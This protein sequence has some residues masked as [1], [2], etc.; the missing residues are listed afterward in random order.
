MEAQPQR[1][2]QTPF[3]PPT[4]APPPT[5]R[6]QRKRNQTLDHLAATAFDLFEA[7]GYDAVTMEQIAAQA[8]VAKGTLYNHFPVKEALLAH[9]F[10]GELAAGL[11]QL[12]GA[13]DGL[14]S[15][16]ARLCYLLSASAD[17]CEA[18]RGYLPH[19]LRF[20]FLDLGPSRFG[21]GAGTNSGTNSDA[22]SRARSDPSSGTTSDASAE[23]SADVS[24][25]ANVG[26]SA[27]ANAGANDIGEAAPTRSGMDLAFDALMAAAQQ[28]GELRR[29]LPSG[30]LATLFHHL[31][32]GALM[33]WLAAP[34]G[35][36]RAEFAAIVDLFFHGAARAAEP[37]RAP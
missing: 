24:A 11:Q 17:W 8:D 9:Q 29:D 37:E 10:H 22:K 35:D 18:R 6:R 30:Q 19:Y 23:S 5:G 27:S 36:L 32:L 20:R 14:G 34:A 33:R 7:H 3:D 4:A 12:R 26:A 15:F 31:Y 1:T 28:S 2:A 21:Q 25:N 16:Q 13:L